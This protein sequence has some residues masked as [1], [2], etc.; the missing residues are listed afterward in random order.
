MVRG[1][2]GGYLLKESAD[3]ELLAAVRAVADGNSY[4]SPEIAG[5]CIE[6]LSEAGQ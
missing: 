2:R 1:R 5:C 4:L 6:R 3:T